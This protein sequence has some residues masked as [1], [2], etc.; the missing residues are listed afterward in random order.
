MYSLLLYGLCH[1]KIHRPNVE[2]DPTLPQLPPLVRIPLCQA[3]VSVDIPAHDFPTLRGA[4]AITRCDWGEPVDFL[5]GGRAYDLV[6]WL[7]VGVE[8]GRIGIWREA[9]GTRGASEPRT[10][11]TCG[12]SDCGN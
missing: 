8:T 1:A 5:L 7:I 2:L 9:G 4:Q 3:Y 10:L 6:P 11:K 12:S